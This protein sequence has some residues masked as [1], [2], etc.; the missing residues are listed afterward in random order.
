[1]TFDGRIVHDDAIDAVPAGRRLC[2]GQ[3]LQCAHAIAPDGSKQVKRFDGPRF[4]AGGN[5]T[6]DCVAIRQQAL[7]VVRDVAPPQRFVVKMKGQR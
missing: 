7:E 4:E 5:S 6:T 2:L 1:M 3:Q